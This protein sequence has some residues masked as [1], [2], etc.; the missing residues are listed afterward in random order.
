[1]LMEQARKE[2]ADFG[3]KM[4]ADGLSKGT[5]GNLNIYDPEYGCQPLRRGL[6]RN[7]ARG[8]GGDDTGRQNYRGQPQALQRTRL[9]RH[10]L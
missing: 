3:R 8:C 2:I 10:L 5:S 4:S 7:R 9:A 1:M 6:L